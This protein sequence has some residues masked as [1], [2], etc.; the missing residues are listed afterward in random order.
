MYKVLILTHLRLPG[1]ADLQLIR[2]EIF[3]EN[4]NTCKLFCMHFRSCGLKQILIR[5]LEK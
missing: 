2:I 5:A 3:I 4:L 1:F